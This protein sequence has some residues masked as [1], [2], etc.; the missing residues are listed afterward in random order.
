MSTGIR[1]GTDVTT[2]MEGQDFQRTFITT[3]VTTA[4]IVDMKADMA[5]PTKVTMMIIIID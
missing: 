2:L 3:R 4:G 5:A 1:P